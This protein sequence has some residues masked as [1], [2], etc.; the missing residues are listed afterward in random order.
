[1]S[2]HDSIRAA[3]RYC[4]GEDDANAK[5]AMALLLTMRGTPFIYYG[6][7]IGMRNISLSRSEIM[8]PVGKYYWPIIKG[9]D[10]CRSPMQWDA[11]PNAG[12]STGKPWLKLHPNYKERNVAAQEEDAD[13]M[14]NFTRRLISLRKEYRALRDGGILFLEPPQKDLLAYL[15]LSTEGTILVALNF[16][17]KSR[18]LDLPPGDWQPLLSTSAREANV[19]EQVTLAPQEVCL[20]KSG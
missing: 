7:E 8:D 12:F 13:S 4:R 3:S 20:M 1:M 19:S 2:N 5:I 6:E 11:T 16:S 14:L 17:N 10:G 15:R 18:K 9:R